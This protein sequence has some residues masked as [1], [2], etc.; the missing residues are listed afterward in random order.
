MLYF[1]FNN[2]DITQFKRTVIEL[3]S[4]GNSAASAYEFVVGT[5]YVF[6]QYI[7]LSEVLI[8]KI[9]ILV[10][11]LIVQCYF[12]RAQSQFYSKII[13]IFYYITGPERKFKEQDVYWK[14]LSTLQY[15]FIF[16]SRKAMDGEWRWRRACRC[17]ASG[18]LN[19][20]SNMECAGMYLN[21]R[22]LLFI[23]I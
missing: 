15:I 18:I 8:T 20:K 19:S 13:I 9:P 21:T 2:C 12:L 11:N 10:M 6:F 23:G 17:R 1:K 7:Y 14:Y 5:Q 16:S 4:K 22:A 3:Q